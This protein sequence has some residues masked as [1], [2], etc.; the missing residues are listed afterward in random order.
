MFAHADK[1]LT[2]VC[3]TMA[4]G[5]AVPK[6]VILADAETFVVTAVLAEDR[7]AAKHHR[8]VEERIVSH[9]RPAN[10]WMGRWHIVCAGN[11]SLRIEAPR[12]ASEKDERGLFA[13]ARNLFLEPFP[14]RKIV[15]ILTGNQLTAGLSEAA[16]KARGQAA[17]HAIG[18][19]AQSR[20]GNRAKNLR[21]GVGRAVIDDQQFPGSEGL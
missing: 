18:Q 12:T 10:G 6:F 16:I 17:V 5:D 9:A 11:A 15:G 1:M 3:H 20:I 19:D 7:V 2:E 14:A 4:R 8:S 21:R 13:K